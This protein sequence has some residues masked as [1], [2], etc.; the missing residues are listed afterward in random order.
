M[1]D[2]NDPP[3]RNTGQHQC[4]ANDVPL[5]SSLD[6]AHLLIL[7][8]SCTGYASDLFFGDRAFS[9]SKSWFAQAGAGT[10]LFI[11][12]SSAEISFPYRF[13]F[14]LP[15]GRSVEPSR[16]TPANAPRARE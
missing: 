13:L 2:M 6:P 12:M 11:T 5:Y 14:A 16:E 8:F 1:G 9:V 4:I 10:A 7:Q 15:S 3:A